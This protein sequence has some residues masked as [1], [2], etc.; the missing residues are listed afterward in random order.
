MKQKLKNILKIFSVILFIFLIIGNI[1]VNASSDMDKRIEM[2]YDKIETKEGTFYKYKKHDTTKAVVNYNSSNQVY[3]EENKEVLRIIED[4][5]EKYVNKFTNED[6]P[7]EQRIESKYTKQVNAIYSIT[8]DNPYNDGDDIVALVSIYV[9]PIDPSSNYWKENF[10]NN[11]TSYN[12][13]EDKY[14]ITMNYFLRLEFN[15]EIGE[16]QIA[17]IDFKPENLDR[18]LSDLK[19]KGIDLYDLDINKIMNIS[20]DDEIRPVASSNTVEISGNKTEYSAANIE[21]ISK[22]AL[23]I[24]VISIILMVLIIAIC[25]IQISKNKN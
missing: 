19:E 6:Y 18:Y 12:Q 9:I 4:N 7:K 23:I 17:Y 14:Y 8:E 3:S 1:E 16:Y 10:T 15:Q 20:Y 21:E 2:F 11:E 24:R 13:F 5:I 22:I 25:V